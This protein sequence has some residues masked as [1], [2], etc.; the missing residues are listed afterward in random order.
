MSGSDLSSNSSFPGAGAPAVKLAFYPTARSPRY[1]YRGPMPLRFVD[2]ETG[3]VVAEATIPIGL[4][5]ALLLF[6][7]AAATDVGAGKLRYQISVLDDGAARHG[8]GPSAR[9]NVAVCEVPAPTSMSY[10]W[11]SAQ[12]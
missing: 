8:S 9:K 4:N 3:A 11:I 10:G 6:S 1:D 5:D 12:P 7:S 2:S